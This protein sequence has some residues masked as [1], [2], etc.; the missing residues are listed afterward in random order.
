MIA[1][2][3]IPYSFI[4]QRTNPSWREVKFGFDQQL[5]SPQVAIDKATERLSGT[6]ETSET[7]V[8]LASRTES[9]SVLELV[10]SLA[11]AEGVS[12]E[13]DLRAKWLYLVLAWLFENRGSVADP[14]G[15]V[16]EVYSD[17]GYP[18]EIASFV[19][20]MPMVGPDLGNREQNEARLYEYWKN[21]LD[22]TGRRFAPPDQAA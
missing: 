2:T 7:E 14:L 12:S 16:E 13:E 19:R 10:S 6:G 20:Y 3:K 22:E 11:D 8:E 21:Y 18:R 17:F 15:M 1:V 9:D 5:I 4:K